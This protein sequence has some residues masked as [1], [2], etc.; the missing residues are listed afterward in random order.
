MSR[1]TPKP[2]TPLDISTLV[3]KLDQARGSLAYDADVHHYD[4]HHSERAEL[5][6]IFD[7][8]IDYLRAHQTPAQLDPLIKLP[9][10]PSLQPGDLIFHDGRP[11]TVRQI[12]FHPPHTHTDSGLPQHQAALEIV[13]SQSRQYLSLIP[14][15]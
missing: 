14:Q 10:D 6:T 4:R 8:L 2:G 11:T 15:V 5:D 7:D 9:T 1:T 3:E 12:H 13:T